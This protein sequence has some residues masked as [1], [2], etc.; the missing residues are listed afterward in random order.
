MNRPTTISQG[1]VAKRLRCCGSSMI[2]LL[3]IYYCVSV[4]VQV[5]KIL[6]IGQ[7]PPIFDENLK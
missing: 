4:C 2:I 3:K 7:L 5:K 1:S 6:N